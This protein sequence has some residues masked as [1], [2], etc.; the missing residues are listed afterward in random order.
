MNWPMLG[1]GILGTIWSWFTINAA[2]GIR[3]LSELT[4]PHWAIPAGEIVSQA[5]GARTPRASIIVPA[6]NEERTIASAMETLMASDYPELEVIAINDRS[7]DRTG[8]VLDGIATRYPDRLRVIHVAE[9]PDGWLGKT[10]A[11]AAGAR[12][13][14]GEW[15]LFTDADVHQRAD[16]MRRAIAYAEG[17]RTD[18]LVVLPSMLTYSWGER[19]MV[20]LFQ[21]IFIFAQRPWKVRDP[22]ARD[23]MG[24]GAFN[25]VR[26]KAYDAIGGYEKLALAVLDDM[27]LGEMVKKNKFRSDCAF[28]KNM[29][30]IYWARGAFG[31]MHNLVKNFFAALR[32]NV[33]FVFFAVVMLLLIH[34]GPWAGA[35]FASGWAKT[36][37]LV[38]LLCILVV[39]IGMSPRSGVRPVYFLLQPIA[40]VLLAYSIALSAVLTLW[41]G[42]VVWRGT[43][44]SLKE[45]RES[46]L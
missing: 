30:E 4:D 27:K 43:K 25:L 12:A 16:L 18:H 8:A 40:A 2:V 44:Y 39:Y 31:M 26:R 29:V 5:T 34:V 15:L 23:F 19:M 11:M 9:L 38:S 14:S 35:M 46:G 37:Y 45:L 6:R 22:N 10:H 24:V 21:A 7:T 13:A 20:A 41:R 28:G 3:K 17:T 33:A 42:G 32:Y 1:G 36:G